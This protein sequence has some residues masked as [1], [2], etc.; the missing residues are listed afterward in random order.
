MSRKSKVKWTEQMNKDVMESKI[1]AK[2]LTSSQNPPFNRIGRKKGYIEVMK[3]IWGEKGYGHLELKSQNLRDHTSRLEKMELEGSVNDARASCSDGS[4]HSPFIVAADYGFCQDEY[5]E[6]EIQN[7]NGR[8][9][10][11]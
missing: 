1:R 10:E 2:D 6:G 8:Q 11:C 9:S 3:E 7:I 5:S 4:N